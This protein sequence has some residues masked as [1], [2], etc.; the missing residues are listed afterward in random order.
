MTEE[1]DVQVQI[2]V[3]QGIDISN[4]RE[5]PKIVG[6]T[7]VLAMPF[8]QTLLSFNVSVLT[9]GLN[10]KASHSVKLSI[11]EKGEIISTM[12]STLENIPD[13][14]GGFVFNF[15]ITNAM[16]REVGEHGIDFY[17][18]GKKVNTQKFW[19]VYTGQDE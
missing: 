5:T 3:A 12:T 2:V 13:F 7:L 11:V 9:Y 16:F 17:V 15:S 4:S 6:P 1:R 10:L 8:R 14:V 19:T 18:D